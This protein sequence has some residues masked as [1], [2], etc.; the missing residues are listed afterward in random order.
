MNN[1]LITIISGSV[2]ILIT[3]ATFVYQ[4][5]SVIVDIVDKEEIILHQPF[6]WSSINWLKVFF[7]FC[8]LLLFVSPTILYVCGNWFN[9]LS[10]PMQFIHSL[11]MLVGV[12]EIYFLFYKEMSYIGMLK[13]PLTLNETTE[14]MLIMIP[15]ILICLYSLVVIVTRIVKWGIK[16]YKNNKTTQSIWRQS[17][18][19]R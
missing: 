19:T 11:F 9:T 13:Y 8:F 17:N 16:S 5:V 18:T 7:Y 10:K 15:L 6:V 1:K 4:D 14:A 2:L 12:C 3:V